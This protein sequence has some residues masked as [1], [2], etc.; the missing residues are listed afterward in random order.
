MICEKSDSDDIVYVCACVCAYAR[1]L[2]SVCVRY[3]VSAVCVFLIFA[4]RS[5][6][7]KIESEVSSVR[8]R[9]NDVAFITS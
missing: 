6:I 1:G 4:F 9:M 7:Q 8:L 5:W 2:M 3:Y